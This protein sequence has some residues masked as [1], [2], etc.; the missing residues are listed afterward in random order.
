MSFIYPNYIQLAWGETA[1]VAGLFM[2][3]GAAMVAILSA[4]SGRWY[5]KSGPL[6]PILTGLIFAVIGGVSIS[7]FFPGLTIYPLLALNVIFMTG[8]GFVMGSN[9]TYSLAQLKPEIQADGNSIVNTLQQFTGA[10]SPTIIARI[11]SSFD[12]NLVTAGRTSILFVT[13]LAVIALVVFLWIYPQTQK[14]N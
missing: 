4:L 14:K 7:F 6:K 8:I 5:D 12:S 3:P 13:T 11:F 9:V 1:T 2:F 10:I